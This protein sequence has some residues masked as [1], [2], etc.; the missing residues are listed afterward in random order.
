MFLPLSLQQTHTI[1][2]QGLQIYWWISRPEFNKKFEDGC[3]T[4]M[5]GP[6]PLRTPGNLQRSFVTLNSRTVFTH[7]N[8]L[9]WALHRTATHCLAAWLKTPRSVKTPQVDSMDERN[10]WLHSFSTSALDRAVWSTGIRRP[11]SVARSLVTIPTP[12]DP[13][14][15][16]LFRY[17][18]RNTVFILAEHSQQGD[19]YR[20]C[21]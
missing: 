4:V 15:P 21:N 16:V 5:V 14:K 20:H 9:T 13:C 12:K 2:Q 3:C 1:S 18:L 11:N 6:C 10:R 19:V 8:R 17:Y 7:T